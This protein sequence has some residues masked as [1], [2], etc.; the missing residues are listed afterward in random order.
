VT[1]Q[2]QVRDL[3]KRYCAKLPGQIEILDQLLTHNCGVDVQWSAPLAR[4]EIITHEMKGTGGSLGF[5]DIAAAA[6]A[7]GDHL[8]LLA[9]Q[10]RISEVQLQAT[11]DLFAHLRKIASQPTAQK[12]ALYDA[13][14]TPLASRANSI[15]RTRTVT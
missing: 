8:K 1:V 3:L 15:A 4:A 12:S 14:L 5:P 9:K 7:L 2:E 13:D 11:K 6:T 10:D